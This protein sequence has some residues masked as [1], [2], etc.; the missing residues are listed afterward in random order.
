MIKVHRAEGTYLTWLDVTG[1][2]ESIN[3]KK[4]ADDYNRTKAGE[5]ADA[6]A[7]ADG[8]ALLREDREGAS[9]S[10]RARTA[11]AARTTCA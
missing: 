2:A 5:H 6:H 9:E 4:L 8:R 1:V 10:G 3:S 11:R 7:G